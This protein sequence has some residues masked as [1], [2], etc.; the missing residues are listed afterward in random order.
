MKKHTVTYLG[1]YNYRQGLDWWIDLLTTCTH[2][3]EL[4]IITALLIIST[5]YKS[6]QLSLFPACCVSNSCSLAT[7]SNSGDSSASLAH[8]VAVQQISRNWT[9]SASLGSSL[10]SLGAEPTENTS[11]NSFSVVVMGSCLAIA[12]ISPTCLP[13]ATKQRM[14]L[15]VIVA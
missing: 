14:L 12:R 5:L 1:V 13:A 7:A 6:R 4:Q 15:L 8:I 9:H 11:T 3:S 2:H 10:Y